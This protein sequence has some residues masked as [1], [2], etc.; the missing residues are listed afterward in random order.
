M[1]SDEE[2]IEEESTSRKAS[3]A[4]GA[5]TNSIAQ[6]TKSAT[7]PAVSA[8]NGSKPVSAKPIVRRTRL[9]APTV[10][11][12]NIS[13]MSLIRNNA[14]KDLSTVAMPIA[15]N[16]PINLLQKLCE[17]LEYSELLEQAAA[18]LDPVIRLSIMAAFAVSAY[19]STVHRAG[20]KPF[21]PLLG[22]TYECLRDDRGF[23][24]VSEKVSHHPPIMACHAESPNYQFFQDS[25][26]KSKFWGKSMELIPLGTVHV[27]FPALNEHYTWNK[28]TTCMR[29][30]FS[31]NRY[32]EHYG[33]LKITSQSTGHYCELTFKE[34]G[35]FSST[36]NEITGGI[37]SSNGQKAMS[38]SGNWDKSLQR[39]QDSS[40]N[41]L[42]VI[43]RAKPNPPHHAE[44]YGFTQFAVE[45]NELTPD[46][47]G[48]LPNTDTRFRPDQRMYEEGR[49]DEAEAEKQRL[50]QKQ[51]DYRKTLETRGESWSPRWF[52]P[53]TTAGPDAWAYK[54]GYWEQRG[55]FENTIDLFS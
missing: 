20:R 23:K 4:F 1:T 19:A 47:D 28:V 41:A 35:Y 17:E 26:V 2:D 22:E 24:F 9:R 30:I 31:A 52:R 39:F 13:I 43:W 25:Q 50:E 55:N 8:Q 53:D 15:L 37:F 7:I 27:A 21:N 6:S 10:S 36:K 45:L 49:A 5:D 12:Q 44:I 16:E 38:L 3:S 34:S 32:L 42:E 54:G 14:G 29:N 46:L 40:P 48:C 11:M 18:T 33:T 51:R